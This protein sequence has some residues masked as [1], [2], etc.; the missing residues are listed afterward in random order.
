MKALSVIAIVACLAAC[1]TLKARSDY[2]RSFDFSGYRTFAWI[3]EKPMIAASPDVSPLAQGRIQR[4]IARELTAKGFRHVPD[5]AAADFV[6]AFTVGTRH[7]ILTSSTEA[8]PYPPGYVGPRGWGVSYFGTGDV[9]AYTQGR[10]A[11][12]IFDV[13]RK[14]PV[15]TGVATK[16]VTGADQANVEALINEAVAKI[17]ATFPPG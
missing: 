16:N 5:P 3:S 2:D 8:Y 1:D 9:D 14:Q 15:W 12:D 7:Q 13:K 10:L 6:V 4:A 17:L 11:I